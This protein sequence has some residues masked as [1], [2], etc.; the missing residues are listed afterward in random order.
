VWRHLEPGQRAALSLA[1]KK[2]PTTYLLEFLRSMP[3]WEMVGIV[4]A[5]GGDVLALIGLRTLIARLNVRKRSGSCS[6]L[7]FALRPTIATARFEVACLEHVRD[8]DR[9]CVCRAS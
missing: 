9:Y 2:A 5:I 4:L 1:R 6:W 8:D 3:V 7:S